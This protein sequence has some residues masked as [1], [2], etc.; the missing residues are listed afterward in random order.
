MKLMMS[1]GISIVYLASIQA[2]GSS[3][4]SYNP[5][6]PRVK[7]PSKTVLMQRASEHNDDG[8]LS[9]LGIIE[10][11]A[12]KWFSESELNTEIY[13]AFNRYWQHMLPQI[14]STLSPQ[15]F[16]EQRAELYEDF[17]AQL[18]KTKPTI[19]LIL[20]KELYEE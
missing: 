2:G 13:A 7:I 18:E 6:E 11:C 17:I 1:I 12:G 10:A 9:Q 20:L 14:Q 4:R 19:F 5:L 3:S 15:E 8:M 16:A